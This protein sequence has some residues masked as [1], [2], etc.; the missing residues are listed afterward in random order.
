MATPRP[1]P[2]RPR[3]TRTTD[4]PDELLTLDEALALLKDVSRSTFFRWK[5]TGKAPKTIK[6][7]NGMIRI[8]RT[9][10]DEWLNNHQEAA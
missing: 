9:D 7:P 3:T 4:N 1:T 2:I 5:A 6:Y 8:R 10:L